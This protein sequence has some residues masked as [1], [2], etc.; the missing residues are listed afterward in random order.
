[1]PEH[2]VD[3]TREAFDA[4]KALPR[5]VPIHMLNLLKFR[6]VAAYPD[7]HEHAGKGWSGMRAYAEYGKTSEPIFQRLG[8]NIIWRGVMEAMVIGPNDKHWDAA[9]IA[10]YPNSAAFMQMV[11]DP[12]Y[13]VA[14]INRQAAVLTSRLIRFKPTEAEG[15]FG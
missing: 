15:G 10:F 4:F 1:M 12:Q 6:E 13:R 7:N 2:Y 8:G 9:F 5:D 11:T 14:V 3:P